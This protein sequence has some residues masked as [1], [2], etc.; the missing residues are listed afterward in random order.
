MLNLVTVEK[1]VPPFGLKFIVLLVKASA[2]FFAIKCTF[3]LAV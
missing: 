1:E 3:S 2:V